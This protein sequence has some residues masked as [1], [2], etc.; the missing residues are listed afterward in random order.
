MF[1]Q[2][3]ETL[4]IWWKLIICSFTCNRVGESLGNN[5]V[6]SCH[7]NITGLISRYNGL[8]SCP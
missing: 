8:M 2:H 1:F 4:L 7:G 6:R 3:K 5:R